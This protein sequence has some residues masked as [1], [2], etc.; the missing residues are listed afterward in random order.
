MCLGD[1]TLWIGLH[2]PEQALCCCRVMDEGGPEMVGRLLTFSLSNSYKQLEMCYWDNWLSH[3][4]QEF[5]PLSLE[6]QII[7]VGWHLWGCNPTV[8]SSIF[9]ESMCTN[10]SPQFHHD[11]RK[12]L[13]HKSL[14]LRDREFKRK[15][16]WK[17]IKTNQNMCDWSGVWGSYLTH[18]VK[19]LHVMAWS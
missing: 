5:T 7:R 16:T 12:W 15:V 10:A 11:R 18:T 1:W 4:S 14:Q 8:G 3:Q 17:L 19:M 13:L 6:Y 9:V 2:P